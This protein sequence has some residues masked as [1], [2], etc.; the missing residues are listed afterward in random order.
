L[1]GK[2]LSTVV[3][4]F[5][6]AVTGIVIKMGFDVSASLVFFAWV[7]QDLLPKLPKLP[8]SAS[9]C[10]GQCFFSQTV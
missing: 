1:A 7:T 6:L 2:N 3:F 8:E 5:N 4:Q 9:G 10:D